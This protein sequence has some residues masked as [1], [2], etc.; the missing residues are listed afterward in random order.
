MGEA[1]GLPVE[2]PVREARRAEDRG[3]RVRSGVRLSL[4]ELMNACVA[5][6][7]RAGRVPIAHQELSLVGCEHRQ[8]DER[9]VGIGDYGLQ[10]HLEAVGQAFDGGRIEQIRHV[11]EGPGELLSILPHEQREIEG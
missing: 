10:Q 5:R 3:D 1:V 4:E 7:R 8:L 6:I 9:T 2:L 11:R